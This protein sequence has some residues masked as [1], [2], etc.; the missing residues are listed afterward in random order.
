MKETC[1]SASTQKE[2][3]K[4][5]L[6]R[7]VNRPTTP[8]RDVR[9]ARIVLH[10]IAGLNQEQT[11]RAVGLNRPVVVHWEKRFRINPPERA[12]VLCCDEKSQCQALDRTQTALPPGPNKVRTGTHDYVRHGTITLFAALSCSDGKIFRQRAP[13]HTHKE[14]LAFLRKLDRETPAD[15]ALHLIIDN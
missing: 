1:P 2:P 14:W 5:E 10:R 4:Q 3:K 15:L 9:R 12:L 11:A 6:H 13:Q 7:T 8:Q